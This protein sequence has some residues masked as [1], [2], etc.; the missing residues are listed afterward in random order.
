M[1]IFL[2]MNGATSGQ[3]NFITVQSLPNDQNDRSQL[4]LDNT[5]VSGNVS[6][7]SSNPTVF[8]S[9]PQC[10]T[11]LALLQSHQNSLVRTLS[12]CENSVQSQLNSSSHASSQNSNNKMMYSQ[13][14]VCPNSN[15]VSDAHRKISVMSN[16]STLSTDSDYVSDTSN[17]YYDKNNIRKLSDVQNCY[18]VPNNADMLYYIKPATCN[19]NLNLL[20]VSSKSP[21]KDQ[22]CQTPEFPLDFVDFKNETRFVNEPG[23][24]YENFEDPKRKI[25]NISTISTLSSLS[26]ESTSTFDT[27][28]LG[29]D[30]ASPNED[31][32]IAR[33][34]ECGSQKFEDH[35]LHQVSHTTGHV[36][37][38]LNHCF[39]VK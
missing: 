20:A 9:L 28:T 34:D 30:N 33:E 11:C 7:R 17:L 1:C 3:S 27:I 6:E 18:D 21:V 38:E 25:S 24:I 4:N 19:L 23:N 22:S 29:P 39:S 35:G 10:D 2:Q 16:Q 5:S 13:L 32:L 8:C 31:T 36:S 12:S 14:N 37:T 26:T 15:A